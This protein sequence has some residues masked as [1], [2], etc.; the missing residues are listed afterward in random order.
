[1]IHSC[2]WKMQYFQENRT[3]RNMYQLEYF[4]I[5]TKHIAFSYVVVQQI[6]VSMEGTFVSN[7]VLPNSYKI[8]KMNVW[9]VK[10]YKSRNRATTE[11]RVKSTWINKIWKMERN[12]DSYTTFHISILIWV[13]KWH[14][15]WNCVY[16]LLYYILSGLKNCFFK[17]VYNEDLACMFF[18]KNHITKWEW[19]KKNYNVWAA[20]VPVISFYRS[21]HDW[22]RV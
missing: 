7:T 8:S 16:Y 9:V 10:R 20:S 5:D 2:I 19:Y 6:L 12:N 15:F 11:P 18:F 13:R 4:H 14:P 21:D 1:M 3:E 17:I 22:S